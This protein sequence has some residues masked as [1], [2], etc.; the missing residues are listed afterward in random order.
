L[1]P[2]GGLAP[3][4]AL[5]AL[6]GFTAVTSVSS[7]ALAAAILERN[8]AEGNLH[9]ARRAEQALED[10]EKY[11]RALIENSLDVVTLLDAQGTVLYESPSILPV[12]GYGTRE[13][14]GTDVFRLIHPED[15]PGVREKFKALLTEPAETQSARFRFRHKDGSWRDLE[16]FGRNALGEAAV[17]G[18]IVN[19][20]DITERQAAR[21]FLW[22]SEERFRQ[23]SESTREGVVI[24]REGRILAT[25]SVFAR[26][27]GY[28]PEE[29]RGKSLA[30]LLGGRDPAL[31]EAGAGR[32]IEFNGVRKD[33]S[34][35]PAEAAGKP[36]SF[37]GREARVDCVTDL[38]RQKNDEKELREQAG[39]MRSIVDNMGE[40]L[41]VCNEKGKTL[42][43]NPAAQA[44]LGGQVGDPLPGNEGPKN[45]VSLGE[46]GPPLS[47]GEFPI[48]RAL[49]GE[50]S[51]N[52]ELFIR[53]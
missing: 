12:L 26:M 10:S 44:I 21:L 32:A 27:F 15:A 43:V 34:T 40:G 37:E 14:V 52:V 6:Q 16:S 3:N 30:D 18:I 23:L 38:T 2:F 31:P 11:Y 33:G 29:V 24:S 53:N 8:L 49:A 51:D 39:L 50:S 41:L 25:N 1:G 35:F 22:E 47:P 20:R 45:L 46:E 13:L 19:S 7:L 5:L 17:G 4:Q 9:K 36:V 42:F 28:D 48:T